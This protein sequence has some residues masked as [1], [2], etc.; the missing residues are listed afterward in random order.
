MQALDQDSLLAFKKGI[1]EFV[2]I[3]MLVVL[4]IRIFNN[5]NL[6]ENYYLAARLC[7]LGKK[8]QLPVN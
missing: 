3:R 2:A 1:E 8:E 4:K 5:R 7:G 6:I